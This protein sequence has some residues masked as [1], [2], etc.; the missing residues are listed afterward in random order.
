MRTAANRKKKKDVRMLIIS[1]DNLEIVSRI[2]TLHLFIISGVGW[3]SGVLV[4]I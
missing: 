3:L 4:I 2:S 1:T